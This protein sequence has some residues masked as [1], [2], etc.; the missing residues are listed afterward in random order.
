MDLWRGGVEGRGRG[1]LVNVSSPCSALDIG[2]VKLYA[3]SI[4]EVGSVPY[5]TWICVCVCVWGD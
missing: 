2:S 4:P 5:I 3:I 1:G